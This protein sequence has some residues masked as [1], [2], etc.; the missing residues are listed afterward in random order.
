V[1][2][3]YCPELHGKTLLPQTH[4]YLSLRTWRNQAGTSLDASALLAAVH[5]AERFYAS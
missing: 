3:G 1:A 2:L 4:T 5:S